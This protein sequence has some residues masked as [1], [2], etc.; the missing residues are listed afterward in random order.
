MI[1]LA[2]MQGR[3]SPPEDNRIQCFPRTSWR[4]EFPRAVE[5]GIPAIEWIDD[6]YGADINPLRTKEGIEELKA[7]MDQHGVRIPSICADTFMEQPLVRCTEHERAERLKLLEHL[8]RQAKFLGA[9]HLGIPLLDNSALKNVEE[10]EVMAAAL[11]KVIPILEKLQMELHLETSLSPKEFPILLWKL[12]HPL[13]RVTYDTGNSASLGYDPHEEFSAYGN[14]I[15]SVHIKDRKR[16]GGT[17]KLGMGNTDFVAVAEE[18]KRIE[19]KGL[20]TMQAARGETGNEVEQ[21]QAY[22]SFADNTFSE[23]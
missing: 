12:P 22:K 6:T 17:V 14:R 11:L 13:I 23:K 20:F 8:F 5:A 9:G 21:L 16:G 19:F 18:L 4:D 7:L 2:V 15:G 3:L 10:I 1:H